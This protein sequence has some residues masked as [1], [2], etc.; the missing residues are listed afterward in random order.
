MVVAEWFLSQSVLCRM[1]FALLLGKFMY[2]YMYVQQG[3]TSHTHHICFSTT[4]YLRCSWMP[5]ILF[6]G[7]YNCKVCLHVVSDYQTLDAND[8]VLVFALNL[9]FSGG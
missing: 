5:L 2:F 3:A 8:L 9:G 6:W 1:G 4:R 7:D